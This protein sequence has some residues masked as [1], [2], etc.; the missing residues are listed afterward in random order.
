MIE[1]ERQEP[2]WIQDALDR[3]AAQRESKKKEVQRATDKADLELALERIRRENAR[4]VTC[5]SCGKV[6]DENQLDGVYLPID[7]CGCG[8][9]R[10]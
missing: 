7:S 10:E 3:L 9:R 1:H 4:Q 8:W 6:N 2:V 5:P